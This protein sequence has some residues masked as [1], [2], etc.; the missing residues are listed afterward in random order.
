MEKKEYARA[1]IPDKP[2]KRLWL[3]PY[4]NAIERI[5]SF[6][7]YLLDHYA[8]SYVDFLI[9]ILKSGKLPIEW[10]GSFA[11]V[12]NIISVRRVRV[13]KIELY[14]KSSEEV[15][16][17]IIM[18]ADIML[19][20]VRGNI[21][22]AASTVQWYRVRTYS[23]LNPYAP[24]YNNL[25][26]VMIYDR[27]EPPP[28]KV[29]DEYLVPYTSAKLL[30]MESADIL[31]EYYPEALNEPCRVSGEVLAE[32][33]HLKVKYYRLAHDCAIRGQMYFEK[34][35]ITVYN[36]QGELHRKL[37]PANT[38]VVDLT[39]C[40]NED[41]SLN[42]E[43]V[44]DTL[45]HEC[46][47]AYRHRLFY[48]GQK[49]YNE[50]IR[51]LSCSVASEQIGTVIDSEFTLWD[52][53][54]P[55]NIDIAEN[56]FSNHN[57]IDWIEW[58]ANRAT[59]RIHMPAQPTQDKIEEL[60]AQYGYGCPHIAPPKIISKVV[61]DLA[62]FFGVSRQSAKLRMIELGYPEAHGVFNY[63]NGAYVADHAFAPGTLG[64]HQT[65]TI[66]FQTAL[67]LYSR[68]KVFRNQINSG[69]YQ[70]IDGHFCLVDRRYIFQRNGGL[71]LTTYAIAHMDECC[72]IFDVRSV[73][74]AYPYQDG[75]LQKES[76]TIAVSAG[77]ADHQTAAL[78]YLAESQRLSKIVYSLPMS[79]CGTLKAHMERRGM[80]IEVLVAKSGVSEAT[81]KRLRNDNAYRPSKGNALAICVGLQL[82][83]VLRRDWLQKVGIAMTASAADMLYELLLD[84]MYRQPVSVINQKLEE[85]GLTPLSRGADELDC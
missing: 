38:I 8:S 2:A 40:T 73:G 42:K 47:H 31:A 77:Y 54:I 39:S 36:G 27:N 26:C 43:K 45:I 11:S 34:R 79:P 60:F 49:L 69:R 83:P 19:Q 1:L 7:Q 35:E 76:P 41:G 33:M 52:S 82:E 16:A 78:D 30:D 59:P 10:H 20:G 46:Y 85:Y 29:L 62:V 32:R 14:R 3:N 66:G 55:E 63:A 56:H 84:S 25:V 64:D 37:I 50:K 12:P 9:E 15:Y 71:H 5:G 72:L 28:G 22:A 4:H 23:S 80:T 44:N 61:S 53:D 70:Y 81:I 67:D 17:D 65:F 74:A 48:L 21:R 57:P 18:S 24:S 13:E 6:K 51:C 68:D 75:L 58:Q